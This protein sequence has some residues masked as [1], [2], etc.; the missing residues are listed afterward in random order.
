MST[1]KMRYIQHDYDV[2]N[3]IKAAM[4]ARG[5]KVLKMS[6]DTGYPTESIRK[7]RTYGARKIDVLID[8]A[9][10][11]NISLDWLMGREGPFD[12]PKKVQEKENGQM[13]KEGVTHD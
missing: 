2:G 12:D 11:L 1:G 9:E 3:R 6:E 5:V 7:F 10:Y 4:K 13:V 8:I